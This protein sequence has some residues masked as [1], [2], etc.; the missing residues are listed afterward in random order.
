MPEII[1]GSNP[2]V[3][4]SGVVPRYAIFLFLSLSWLFVKGVQNGF[5][6]HTK[7]T[8]DCLRFDS[9]MHN[10]VEKPTWCTLFHSLYGCIEWVRICFKCS[11]FDSGICNFGGY[12]D[13]LRTF[14]LHRNKSSISNGIFHILH[15]RNMFSFV[16]NITK[17]SKRTAT[18]KKHNECCGNY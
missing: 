7:I 12:Y 2:L 1:K 15:S 8:V 14:N 11:W 18:K 17:Y 13:N 5:T 16:Y 4:L 6:N 9:L 10:L 3:Q